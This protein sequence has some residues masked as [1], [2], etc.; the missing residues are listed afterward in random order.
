[1]N[2]RMI[3]DAHEKWLYG[4]LNGKRAV[5][6]G[7]KLPFSNLRRSRLRRAD[8]RRIDLR[9]SDMRGAELRYS[10]F[11]WADLRYADLSGAKLIGADLRNTDLRY[12]NLAFAKLQSADLTGAD[13]RGADL[14]GATGIVSQIDFI[15]ENFEFTPDGVIVYKTFGEEYPPPQNWQISPGS[16]L[17]ENVNYNRSDPCGCGINVGTLSY[18]KEHCTGDIW[19]AR[20]SFEWLAGVCVPYQSI[21]VVRCEKIQLIEIVEKGWNNEC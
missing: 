3:L 18:V 5:L 10:N 15:R 16:T 13:L 7:A 12:A 21:G 17:S 2:L 19:K 8:M 20:I 9:W 6:C 11:R 4:E 1:M 14:S